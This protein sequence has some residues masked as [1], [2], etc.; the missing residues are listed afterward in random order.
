V[1][2]VVDEVVELEGIVE[3][4]VVIVVVLLVEVL[5]VLV[6]SVVV[7]TPGTIE[8]VIEPPTVSSIP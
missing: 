1:V 8:T 5:V 3:V 7:V 6:A 2:V 4:L